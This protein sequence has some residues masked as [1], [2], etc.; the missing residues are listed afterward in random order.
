[1]SAGR[2]PSEI[3]VSA[4]WA[5]APGRQVTPLLGYTDHVRLLRCV[6][7]QLGPTADFIEAQNAEIERLYAVLQR[8]RGRVCGS[9]RSALAMDV[10]AE[11]DAALP[12][13]RFA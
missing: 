7:A 12:D 8:V 2:E 11:V 5:A 13:D 4:G 6:P 10:L 9:R 1:M 3:G